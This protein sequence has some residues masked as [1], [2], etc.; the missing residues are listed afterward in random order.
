MRASIL[1]FHSAL[2]ALLTGYVQSANDIEHSGAYRPNAEPGQEWRSYL[3]DKANTHASAL[4]QIN[5]DNVHQLQEAWRYDAGGALS[6]GI[7]QMQCNPVVVKG[8]LYC[9]APDLTAF[10]LNAATGEELWRFEDASADDGIGVYHSR[11]VSYWEQGDD[12]RILFTARDRL[13]ALNAMTGRVIRSFGDGGSVSLHTGLPDWAREQLVISTT[14][15][16]VFENLLILGARVGEFAGSAPGHVR[17]FDVVTGQLQWLFRTIPAAGE[18]GSET[19]PAEA[20]EKAGGANAWAGFA[21]D[22]ERELLFV[23]TGSAT[24]D[25]YGADRIG[26]NLYANTLLALNARTGKRVWHYQFVRH[27]VWDRDLPAPPNLVT[28]NVAGQSVPAV[29]QA[30]K[31]G[32][33]FLFHRETGELLSPVYEEPVRGQPIV[34]DQLSPSQPLPLSPP[35]F[36]ETQYRPTDRSPDSSAYV[37][38]AMKELDPFSSFRAPS[39]RGT[40]LYPGTDGGAEWGGMAYHQRSNMLYVNANEVPSLLTLVPIEQGEDLSLRMAYVMLCSAC[41]GGDMR[42]DG[43]SIPSLVDL[44]DRMGPLDAY[45]FV[46]S[47]GGR[48]PAID[49]LPWYMPAAALAYIYTVSDE[50]LALQAEKKAGRNIADNQQ[51]LNAG[52]QGFVDQEGLPASKPPWGSLSAIDLNSQQIAWRIPLGDYPKALAK[53]YSGLGSENYGGPVVTAGDLLFIA[54][55]PDRM[56]KAYDRRN[57]ELLWQAEL[58]AA[59]FATPTTYAV[60]GRQYVVIAAGGGKLGQPTGSEYVAFALPQM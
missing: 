19:W 40:I 18:P 27:D 34:G 46:R 51:Y 28:L 52:F 21:L 36:I 56:F 11:G 15:G 54:A 9:T 48:M 53:G 12:R 4:K 13:Y 17:A 58:P 7:S 47:G 43:I 16:T 37:L 55:T 49:Q 25:F 5:T 23:P 2:L 31:T 39:V 24:F 1:L 30:T 26:D 41:H 8:I 20:L 59:G 44:G 6:N 57:G 22:A 32:H 10:A 50:D 3:G 60:D 45:R 35:P 42:G 29:A 14:P 33:V 38:A